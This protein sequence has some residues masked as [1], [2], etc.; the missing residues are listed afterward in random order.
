MKLSAS[1]FLVLGLIAAVGF[2]GATTC[3]AEK[4]VDVTS[5]AVEA[6]SAFACD[7]YKKLAEEN[8]GDNLF[9]SPY[10]I[11]SALMM[12]AE[13][14]R[15]KTADEM[16]RVLGLTDAMRS[17]NSQ[18]PWEMEQMH[19]GIANISESLSGED[20]PAAMAGIRADI[21]KLRAKLAGVNDRIA[22][23]RQSRKWSEMF[24]AQ[25]EQRAVASEL[26]DLSSQVDQYEIEVANALWG[27]QTYDFLQPYIDRIDRFYGTGGVIPCDFKNSFPAERER[28][29]AWAADKTND[30][31]KDI[32]PKLPP[33]EARLMRLILTNAIY[34]KG[35]WSVPF[36][37][38]QT[39][40]LDFTT[41]AG[42]PMK[43]PIMHAPGLKGASYA[44]FNS[45]GSFFPTPTKIMRGQSPKLYPAADGFAAVELP[46]KGDDL[47]MV[48]LVPGSHD[49][50]ADLEAKLSPENLDAWIGS[51]KKRKTNVF[52]PK[53]KMETDYKMKKTLQSMGMVRAF[54][55]PR[56][57]EMGADFTG[58]SNPPSVMDRLYIAKVLHKAFVEVNEK[59]TEAAAVTA[60][61]MAVPTSAPISRP[62]TPT[63]R[64]DR[65]FIFL[66]RDRATGSILFLG[67]MTEP[68]K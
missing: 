55:D 11:S 52:L 8:A 6:N 64:A 28:I 25:K 42:T 54:T 66:I 40:D 53:F 46:Y 38:E 33:E 19:Q 65:P 13:G 3:F 17:G 57:G 68:A 15:N 9:F 10:S 20:D 4:P 7:L 5:Q 23:L 44:A 2:G 29:N 63:I 1:V 27:E 32:I 35:D 21:D 37:E 24:T 60:V 12:T 62:F 36:K 18:V 31:I 22:S 50:L 16:G 67:R 45:D 34:F 26:N 49:G 41:S 30:R 58:I 47:S 51:L 43:T 48:V 39:K 14:A 56:M 59:G 61:M